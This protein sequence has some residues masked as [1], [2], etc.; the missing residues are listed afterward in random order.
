VETRHAGLGSA[1][2]GF[3]DI[4]FHLILAFADDLFDPGR[5]DF[6]PS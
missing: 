2:R 1:C 3:A 5:M 6:R 4:L